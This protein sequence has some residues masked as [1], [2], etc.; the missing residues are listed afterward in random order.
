LN[1]VD[2]NYSDVLQYYQKLNEEAQQWEEWREPEVSYL[3]VA[4]E[5]KG[6]S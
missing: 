1:G 2:V 5:D 6:L 4:A 3:E